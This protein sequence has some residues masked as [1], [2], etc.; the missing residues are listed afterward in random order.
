IPTLRFDLH[1]NGD[2]LGADGYLG[3]KEQVVADLRA[4]LD[5]LQAASGVQ[6]FALVGFCSGALPSTWTAQHDARVR[7][8]VLYDA[9]SLQTLSSR[10]RFL[11]VRLRH[12]GLSPAALALYLRR[13]GSVFGRLSALVKAQYWRTRAHHLASDDMQP[14]REQLLQA[15]RQLAARGVRVSVLAAGAD[16]SNV[17]HDAQI[18]EALGLGPNEQTGLHTGF[19]PQIDH[20]MTSGNAQRAFIDWICDDVEAALAQQRATAHAGVAG[21]DTVR[22]RQRHPHS[23]V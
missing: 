19:L 21:R 3:Y 2:S 10:L 1:G 22:D 17:N 23:P 6:G 20:I 9:F 11:A 7:H 16:F 5:A 13:L 12:H 14:S 15:W 18:V 8:I 4:A